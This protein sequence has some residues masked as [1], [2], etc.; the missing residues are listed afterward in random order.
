MHGPGARLAEGAC[1]A[2]RGVTQVWLET[3]RPIENRRDAKMVDALRDMRT[4]GDDIAIDFADP[5][6]EPMLWLPDAV[7]GAVGS[8]R[9]VAEPSLLATLGNRLTEIERFLA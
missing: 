9:R 2:G 7:A 5:M 1:V 8:A 3:R 6:T 4:I